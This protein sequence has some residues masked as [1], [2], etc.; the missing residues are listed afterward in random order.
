MRPTIH[1]NG[2]SPED[3]RDSYAAAR[4]LC[5][6]LGDA[7]RACTPNGRDYYPQGPEALPL[8]SEEHQ[9]RQRAVKRLHDELQ[10]MVEHCQGA[11]D[12]RQPA[13]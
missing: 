8:A 3:L 6:E 2:S 9:D 7:L 1:N 12:A 13:R 11:I 4:R 10:L 5:R